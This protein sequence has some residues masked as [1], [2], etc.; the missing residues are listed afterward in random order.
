MKTVKR[1]CAVLLLV[2]AGFLVGYL[3]YTAS[4]LAVARQE[5]SEQRDRD[6]AVLR[7]DGNDG[8]AH[9]DD[10]AFAA[11]DVIIFKQ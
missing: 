8:R 7:C 9:A 5:G 4:R 1:F 10:A 6:I 2:A 11:R 3:C